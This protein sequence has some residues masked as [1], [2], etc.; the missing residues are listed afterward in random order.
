MSECG[1]AAFIAATD[2]FHDNPIDNLRG[3][4]DLETAPSV[5]RL[6]KR[7]VTV[8]SPEAG[9]SI[10]LMTYPVIDSS[11]LNRSTRRNC[12]VDQVNQGVSDLA[13]I[14]PVVI[15]SY[16]AAN[17]NNMALNNYAAEQT[18]GIDPA[19]LTSPSRIIGFGVECRDVTAELYKQGLCTVF[20]VPQTMDETSA[21]N[22][23][24]MTL[25]SGLTKIPTDQTGKVFCP[26][27][28]NVAQALLYEGSRQWEA[29]EGA[30]CVISFGSK[31]NIACPPE[32]T[33]PVLRAAAADLDTVGV[34]NTTTLY[35]GPFASGGAAGD[36][37]VFLAHMF[38]PMH[39]KGIILSGLSAQSTFQFNINLF[40]ETFPRTADD[41]LVTLARPS[42]EFDSAALMA[43]SESMKTLPVG[44]PVSE[45]GLGD[46]FLDLVENLA[47]VVS[48]MASVA[49]PE[50][51]PFI[52][53]AGKLASGWAGQAK[54][55]NKRDN[56]K[57]KNKVV[58]QALQTER[59]LVA[60]GKPVN[61]QTAP[62]NGTGSPKSVATMAK[63]QQGRA[64]KK[65][66]KARLSDLEA[67]LD[68]R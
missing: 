37:F 40:I 4:P 14:C 60:K 17:S 2:P 63:Q 38:A 18:L 53:S 51:S 31:D 59:S 62:P 39:S 56:S 21:F 42:C 46:F 66:K 19:Y 49:F 33:M 45:N 34:L 24:A 9:G 23:K 61:R 47:P 55:A 43:I 58:K 12:I 41:P 50:F 3:W 8:Q 64:K 16:T 6:V 68:A 27:V 11:V 36:N 1:K 25:T 28:Q 13:S 15:H 22:F 10:Q 65:V 29:K 48:T 20:Q 44:V 5:I 32:Y 54:K 26:Q 52:L 35:T 30:Y 67:F 7:S 57:A